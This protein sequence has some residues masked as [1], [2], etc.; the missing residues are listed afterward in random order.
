MCILKGIRPEVCDIPAFAEAYAMGNCSYRYSSM[1]RCGCP[2]LDPVK[3]PRLWRK[4]VD[5]VVEVVQEQ[6]QKES[7]EVTLTFF[8]SGYLLEDCQLLGE[9][10]NLSE[11]KSWKGTL[12]LQFVD[13]RYV[14]DE[15][16]GLRGNIQKFDEKSEVN[17]GL[18]LGAATCGGVGLEALIAAGRT[19][20]KEHQYKYVGVGVLLIIVAIVLAMQS[21][22]KEKKEKSLKDEHEVIQLHMEPSIEKAIGGFLTEVSKMLPG[23]I[24]LK[25]EFFSY[26]TILLLIDLYLKEV[27]NGKS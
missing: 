18:I 13:L 27:F 19:D 5:S 15:V 10:L 22:P 2:T 14:I 20:K 7:E 3:N 8:A 17:W 25:T 23:G 9:I 11:I 21:A 4:Y 24:E 26:H 6:L 16:Q 12:N 1:S